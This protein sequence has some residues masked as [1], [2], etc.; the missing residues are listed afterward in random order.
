MIRQVKIETYRDWRD[1]KNCIFELFSYRGG[2]FCEGENCT[3][4]GYEDPKHKHGAHY[5]FCYDNVDEWKVLCSHC[6][7]QAGSYRVSGLIKLF[8]F[9][10]LIDDDHK[11]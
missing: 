8:S 4:P 1:F 2:L 11:N 5:N 3:A 7:I 9:V 6:Y 10:W